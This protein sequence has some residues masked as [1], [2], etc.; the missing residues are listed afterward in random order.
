MPDIEMP[1]GVIVSFPDDYTKEQIAEV[2]YTKFPEL[3]PLNKGTEFS[4]GIKRGV[5]QTKALVTE[6]VPAVAQGLSNQ[7]L[8][9]EFDTQENLEAYQ[10]QT[11]EA[12]EK[13]PT[14]TPSFKNIDGLGDV[15]K[16]IASAAGEQ[17]P[18]LGA[19]LLGGG[20]GGFAAKQGVQKLAKRAGK[21]LTEKEL[22]KAMK[23]G[24]TAGTLSTSATQNVPESYFNL[25]SQGA[26]NPTTALLTGG[27]KTG[28]DVIP[29]IKILERVLGPQASDIVG[30][31][32]LKRI[33]TAA[34]TTALQEGVTESAQESLDLV[35]EK[36]ILDN[37]ILTPDNIEQ[38]INAGLKGAIGGG[39]TA[40]ALAP[41]Q[42]L[43][44][45]PFSEKQLTPEQ[46]GQLDQQFNEEIVGEAVLPEV[47]TADNVIVPTY[48]DSAKLDEFASR[49]VN[50]ESLTLVQPKELEATQEALQSLTDATALTDF[51][52]PEQTPPDIKGIA[53]RKAEIKEQK[54]ND[55][56]FYLGDGEIVVGAPVNN[57]RNLTE[58]TP[59]LATYDINKVE[60]A[61]RQVQPLISQDFKL[62]PKLK[63][64][65]PKYNKQA[66]EFPSDV[67]KAIY[68]AG[69]APTKAKRNVDTRKW[70]TETVGIPEKDINMYATQMKDAVKNLSPTATNTIAVPALEIETKTQ[71]I[72]L[73]HF[74]NLQQ[75]YIA[76]KIVSNNLGGVE[77]SPAAL[78]N[79]Q[80]MLNQM[81]RVLNEVAG[82]GVRLAPYERLATGKLLNEPIAGAQYLNTVA[83]ALNA[84]TAAQVDET[85]YHEA[86]H[87]L[88]HNGA[89]SEAEIAALDRK[90]FTLIDYM[91]QDDYLRGQDFTMYM[92][93]PEGREELRANAFGKWA[94]AKIDK[95]SGKEFDSQLLK[96]FEEFFRKA[97]NFLEKYG[98]ALRGLGY[99]TLDD[100]FQSTMDGQR[101][102]Q[103]SLD[104][105]NY[106]NQIAR[107]QRI[108]EGNREFLNNERKQ[109]DFTQVVKD[110]RAAANTNTLNNGKNIGAYTRY[111]RSMADAASDNPF[112]AQIFASV[113]RRT[114]KASEYLE[115]YMTELGDFP[116][117]EKAVRHRIHDLM[118]YLRKTDQKAQIDSE[119]GLVF[120]KN[121]KRVRISDPQVIKQFK[122]VEATYDKVL[123]DYA[124]M[125]KEEAFSEFNDVLP[126]AD[127]N[128]RDIDVAISKLEGK[129]GTKRKVERLEKL[130]KLLSEMSNMGATQFVPHMRFGTW[131]ITVRDKESGEQVA[132]YT[133]EKGSFGKLYNKF[134]MQSTLDEIKSKYAD[135]SKYEVVGGNGNIKTLTMENMVPFKLT[136]NTMKNQ[137]DTR[138]MNIELLSS[139]LASKDLDPKDYES[140]KTE[141]F[142]DILN[143]GFATRFSKAKD[144]DGYSTDWDRVQ[145]AYLTGASHYLSGI[146][147][148]REMSLLSKEADLLADD[149]LKEKAQRY[150]QY[151][152]S[153]AEDMQMMRSFNFMWTMGLNLSTAALQVMTLPTTTLGSMTQYNPNPL[154]NMKYIG[155]WMNLGKEFFPSIMKTVQTHNGL[156]YADFRND[157]II[158]NLIQKG[159]M[160]EA[161]AKF[162]HK[163]SPQLRGFLTEEYSGF[164]PFETRSLGGSLKGKLSTGANTLG[165]PISTMEQITRFATTMASF[166][167]LQ[168]NPK[169]LERADKILK[170]DHRFQAQNSGLHDFDFAENVAKFSMDEAHAVFGKLGRPEFM[171]G[172]GGALFFPFMTYPQQALEFILRAGNRG[173]EGKMG[174][175]TTVGALFMFSGLLGLPGAELLKEL[176]EEIE[177]QITGSEE[178]L[179]FL[180][181]EK[182][183]DATGDVKFGKFIT[184]GIGRAYGD[185]DIARRV[186]LPIPGQDLLLNLLGVKGT[187][188]DMFGVSGSLMNSI[189][190]GFNEMNSGAPASNVLASLLPVAPANVVKAINM[191][192]QGVSTTKG[193]QLLTP[194]EVTT[195]TRL[196]KAVGIGTD[197]L[198][199]KREEAFGKIIN[200]RKHKT[201]ID[202][203]RTKAKRI[204]VEISKARTQQDWDKVREKQLA[205][206][207]ILSE[208]REYAIMND[209]KPDYAAFNRSVRKSTKQRLDPTVRPKDVRKMARKDFFR[210]QEA[211][212]VED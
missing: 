69:T 9:T 125:M 211:L 185:L 15:G 100:I 12:S 151:A 164:K 208:F 170:N 81:Q 34:G 23:R 58:V 123:T 43:D 177:K 119:G 47:N 139:L 64:A 76:P 99:T 143:K 96:L 112:I 171:R 73:P 114:M 110:A 179:D 4:R 41:L 59:R 156:F 65:Q 83:I 57:Q 155:K 115:G 5:A 122:Q 38:I 51:T 74:G 174:A 102:V 54:R 204:D 72:N 66:L 195:R 167:M 205:Y 178:D 61:D 160:T 63:G 201:A 67:E 202:R 36:F 10:Q 26:D 82:P 152:N 183:Y 157:E 52:V 140:L 168:S 173:P 148:Q 86:W 3:N 130:K 55:N 93:T 149:K 106:T 20:V 116:R 62:P 207:N 45:K 186:G 129:K 200:D 127:F 91:N 42:G 109:Q 121:D 111:L 166:D 120:N 209:I 90:T 49:G 84:D 172:V 135:G 18:Q 141:V 131:G 136:H 169:A 75:D 2:A 128:S 158:N 92:S 191:G 154:S 19:S 17:I 71:K 79:L 134:Q 137:I 182:I 118:D 197:Q 1:D 212:G 206:R 44:S 31:T 196:A 198:A 108:S 88:E 70:L 77:L 97:L 80:P 124:N 107:L 203:F 14:A 32:L 101:S 138:F 28:L 194:E 146:P 147:Q 46:K 6:G 133:V 85:L 145:H 199:T 117:Q 30:D 60:E 21:E 50:T 193:Q 190:T 165:I 176:Y 48:Y 24:L 210:L 94:R 142:N 161:Q 11:Q 22:Q 37:D 8:G 150:L 105:I 98:N 53:I 113:E 35:A 187:S 33:G 175:L 95:R 68:T 153:P 39:A 144:Y 13:Y 180:I 25:L 29:Q 189:A 184:Q 162:L 78:D 181:R 163:M 132:F 126:T 159:K 7:Y 27:L 103:E 192:T 104:N 56:D 188:A 16:F 89:F 40:G 87:F